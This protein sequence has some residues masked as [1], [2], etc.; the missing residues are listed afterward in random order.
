MTLLDSVQHQTLEL[1]LKPHKAEGS[2]G[3]LFRE[4]EV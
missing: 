1:L 2:V 3:L 4:T